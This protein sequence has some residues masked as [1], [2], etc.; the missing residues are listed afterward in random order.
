MTGCLII[1]V[2]RL[3]HPLECDCD[4]VGEAPA[5]S[6]SRIGDV[7]LLSVSRA[8]TP[9]TASVSPGSTTVSGNTKTFS[10]GGA[11]TTGFTI[12]VGGH[13]PSSGV[14]TPT[15]QGYIYYFR[16]RI[17]DEYVADYLPCKR[18]SDGVE[19]FWDCVTQTFI[20]PI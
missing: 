20:E 17:D 13:K 10:V 19:G 14:A 18:L 12:P 2:T 6:V 7:P 9:L 3:T 1:D 5:L 15:Y 8:D 16:M 11:F 4:R